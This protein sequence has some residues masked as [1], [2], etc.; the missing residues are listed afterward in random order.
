M[1]ILFKYCADV[2]NYESFRNF[3]FIYIYIYIKYIDYT[4]LLQGLIIQVSD[5]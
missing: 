4:N 1:I 2:K 3:S 5:T